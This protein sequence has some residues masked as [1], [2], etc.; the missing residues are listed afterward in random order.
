MDLNTTLRRSYD[1]EML[2]LRTMFALDPDT[3]MPIS[4]NYVVTTDGI[5]GLVWLNP[6]TNLSTAG[7]GIGYLPSTIDGL[8]SNL[9]SLS[10]TVNQ[11]VVSVSSLST[12]LGLSYVSTGIYTTQLNS[13]LEGLGTFGFVSTSQ[14]TSTTNGLGLLG[15]ISTSQLLSTTEGLLTGIQNVQLASTVKGLGTSGYISSLSLDST[16]QAFSTLTFSTFYSTLVPQFITPLQLTSTVSSLGSL[17]YVSSSQLVSTVDWFLNTSGYVSSGTFRST[18]AGLGTVGYISSSGIQSTVQGLGTY[19]YISTKSLN[20]TLDGLG[21][22]GYVSAAIV[23]ASFYIDNGGNFNILGGTA[24][25]SS[26]QAVVFLSTF[27]LSSLTY[28]GNNG[29]IIPTRYPDATLGNH[30]FFSTARIRLDQFSSYILSSS[31]INLEIYPTFV[32]PRLNTG[33]SGYSL[34]N[35]STMIAYSNTFLSPVASSWVYAG[36]QTAGFGNVFQQPIHMQIPGSL[37]ANKYSNDYYLVHNLV[38]SV[39]SNLAPGFVSGNIEAQF[40]STNSLFLS[41]QNLP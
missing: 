15:Y 30:M 32:F 4:T 28:M 38:S 12:V 25:V 7:T 36:T 29:T 9:S 6:F 41:I 34:I 33:A 22:L 19:G 2:I 26:A 39:T 40:G 31:R 20:S 21:T 18:V 35:M 23:N 37:I 14:L 3:N 1:T 10:T 24:I 16:I 17:G 13:T 8:R 27:V 5:G 11:L